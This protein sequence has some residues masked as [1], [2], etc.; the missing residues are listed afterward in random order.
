MGPISA[1]DMPAGASS[2]PSN[3][4]DHGSVLYWCQR[5][6]KNRPAHLFQ[7]RDNKSTKCFLTHRIAN[8]RSTSILSVVRPSDS[9]E[10]D[11]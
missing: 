5:L 7:H 1:L 3:G 6:V 8:A 9:D 11:D 10:R 4:K 2:N